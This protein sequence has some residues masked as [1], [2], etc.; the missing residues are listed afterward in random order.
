M[1]EKKLSN[2][3][4]KE[5]REYKVPF[6]KTEDELLDIIRQLVNRQHTYDTCVYAMSIAA[7]AAFRYVASVLGTTG[8]QAGCAD[9]DFLRRTR[10][11][12]HG[13]MIIDYEKLIYPQYCD[14]EYF[15]TYLELLRDNLEPMQ[16]LVRKKMRDSSFVHPD[17]M[18]HWNWILSLDKD[19]LDNLIK[20]KGTGR[21]Y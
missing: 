6:P 14:R 13:F 9:L 20:K 12:D 10:S 21:V 1:K 15:P 3:N 16:K 5:L 17:V 4:E 19:K 7:V 18:K 2:M 11:M 8:F